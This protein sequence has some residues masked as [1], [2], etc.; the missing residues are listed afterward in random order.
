M[1]RPDWRERFRKM[2]AK[3]GKAGRGKAKRRSKAHYQR[4]A[5]LSALAKR[6]KK[7]QLPLV[8]LKKPTPLGLGYTQKEFVGERVI[9]AL[10]TLF[11]L[12]WKKKTKKRKDDLYEHVIKMPDFDLKLL[13][14]RLRIAAKKKG[15]R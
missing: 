13:R 2:A 4:M 15:A 12:R 5:A 3:G 9:P 11:S 7:K 6:R 8:A 14:R 1:T 10:S